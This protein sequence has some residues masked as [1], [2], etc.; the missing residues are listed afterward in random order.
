VA[1]TPAPLPPP[2]AA[3][4]PARSLLLPPGVLQGEHV[5]SSR[6]RPATP[7][8]RRA[9]L[10]IPSAALAGS[11]SAGITAAIIQRR[12]WDP[13]AKFESGPSYCSFKR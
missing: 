12:K 5:E 9:A 11:G 13:E 7:L 8:R 3:G 1:A 6:A 4:D 10:L 2:F